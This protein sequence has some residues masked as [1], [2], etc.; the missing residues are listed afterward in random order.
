MTHPIVLTHPIFGLSF[1]FIGEDIELELLFTGLTAFFYF[2][3]SF[4]L[5]KY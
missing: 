1:Q 3:I 4:P 2:H 5:I